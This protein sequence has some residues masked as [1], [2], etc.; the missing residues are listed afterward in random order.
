MSMI[1][2][3]ATAFELTPIGQIESGL[4]NVSEAP[5]QG[6]MGA[7]DAWIRV[8]DDVMKGI[9]DIHPGN[10]IIVLTWLHLADRT[11]LEVYPQDNRNN[12]LT[13]VFATRSADRPNP[14]G[15]H[16]VT[17]QEI[18]KNRIKVAPIEA[19]DGTPVID[20]KPVI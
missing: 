14:I 11:V 9:K 6:T 10:K 8:N 4:S 5:K 18:S 20:I 12:P 17:V 3:R 1:H 19:V 2:S 15:L 7:P 16:E 13:S